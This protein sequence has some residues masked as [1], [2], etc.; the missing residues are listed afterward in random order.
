MSKAVV[1]KL[2]AQP[3]TSSATPTSVSPKQAAVP[4][5]T[6]TP[7]PALRAPVGQTG[8][9]QL[10]FSA[11]FD[12]NGLNGEK[13]VTCY[14]WD[15]Q[16]CTIASNHELQWYRRENVTVG[17]G[18]AHLQARREE[19]ETADGQTFAYTSGMISSGRRVDD[20]TVSPKFAFHYGYAEMRAKVPQGQGLWSAFWLLPVDHQS[21]PEIDV[22]EILGHAP[23]TVEMHLHYNDAAGKKQRQGAE[24]T[25][26]DLSTD[27]HVFAVDWQPTQVIWYVDGVERWRVTEKAAIPAEPMYLIANLA[28]GGD[29][30]GAPDTQTPFPSALLIDYIRVWQR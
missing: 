4:T 5:P 7:T 13:W 11:D 9:W 19:I 20:L 3:V 29:W 30:P 12:G 24:W 1:T 27:W 22:M 21:R 26:P 23:G 25:G 18:M 17:D 28:V 8:R 15:N 10:R 2:V 6:L 16:G 14:W